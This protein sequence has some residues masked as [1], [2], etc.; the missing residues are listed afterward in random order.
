VEIG[1]IRKFK[2]P[3]IEEFGP[4]I[5]DHTNLPSFAKFSYL[6]YTIFPKN[7]N[8]LGTHH[9]DASISNKYLSR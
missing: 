9:V 6:E 4:L 1:N 7:K 2:L 5:V 8:C 3:V